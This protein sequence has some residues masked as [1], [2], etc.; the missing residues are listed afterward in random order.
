MKNR[1]FQNNEG[2]SP[3]LGF[4]LV[5]AIG[6][7]L[8]TTV[9]LSFVP[10]WNTQEELDHIKLM[11]DDFKLL[12]SNI[13]R[14]IQSGTTLSSPLIMGFKYSPKM[15]VYNPKDEAYASL[16]ISN[17]TWVEVRYNEVFYEGMTD[18]TSIKNIS[19]GMITYALLGAQNYNSFIYENGL[20]RRG[21]TNYTTNSQTV[22]AN[23]TI[24]LPGV[25]ALEYGTTSG[26]EKRTVNIYPTSQQKNSVIGK[27]VWLI[28]HTD[29]IYVDWW[30]NNL[31][32]EGATVRKK[33]RTNGIVIANVSSSLIIKM[34]EAYISTSQKTSPPHSPATRLVKVSGEDRALPVGGTTRIIVEVQDEY[35]NPV[36]NFP[37]SFSINASLTG[38][39]SNSYNNATI[40]PGSAVSGSDGRAS[41]TLTANDG[42]FY[43][44]DAS[45]T[46]YRTTLVYSASSQGGVMKLNPTPS[47]NDYVITATLKNSLGSPVTPGTNVDFETSDGILSDNSKPTAPDGTANTTLNVSDATGLKI[48]NIQVKDIAKYSA[49][50]T[51]D[52]INNIIVTAK[53]GYVFNSLD[54]PNMVIASGCVFYSTSPGNYSTK[55]CD[56]SGSSHTAALYNLL[57][58]TPYYFIING[59]RPDGSSVNSTE[60]MFVTG[61]TGDDTPPASVTG[62]NATNGSLYIIWTWTDPD[63]ADF[64][65]TDVMIDDVLVDTVEKGIQTFNATYLMPNSSHN[66]SL[67][68]VDTSNNANGTWE[69]HNSSTRSLL[70]YVFSF[71][72]ESGYGIVTGDSNAQ[73]DNDGDASALLNE[74][75]TSG[76]SMTENYTY[77]SDKNVNI[78]TIGSFGNMQS[79]ADAGAFAAFTEEAVGTPPG[80]NRTKNPGK[81]ITTGTQS[82]SYISSNLDNIDGAIDI[83]IPVISGTTAMTGYLTSTVNSGV[84]GITYWNIDPTAGGTSDISTNIRITGTNNIQYVFRPG[85]QNSKNSGT[86]GSVPSGYGWA[87]ST[88][89]DGITSAGTWSF[90][91]RTTST[92]TARSGRILVY[93]YKYNTTSGANTLLFSVIGTANHMG[94][95]P[96][97]ETITSSLQPEYVF[98]SDEYLKVEYWL[99]VI[100]ALNNAV[101]TFEANS[102]IPYVQY[103][104]NRYSLNTSYIFTETNSSS[105]WQSISI[106]DSSYGNALANVSILNFTSGKWESILTSTFTGGTSPTEHVNVLKGASGNA[107]KY[108]SGSDQIKLMYN[109]TGAKFNNTL[110]IDLINVTVAYGTSAYGLNIT[111]NTTNVPEDITSNYYLEI[112]YSRDAG[113]TGY[114]VFV[115]NGTDWDFKGYLTSIPWT[116]ANFTLS[117][118]EIINGNVDVLYLDQTPAGPTQGNLYIDYQRV[119]NITPAVP[120]GYHLDIRANHTGIPDAGSHKLQIRYNATGDNFTLQVYNGSKP[121]W[122]N[123]AALNMTSS[124][125]LIEVPLNVDYLLSD[126]DFGSYTVYNLP[127]YYV[128]VRYVDKR[129]A[130]P[131]GKLYLDYQRVNSS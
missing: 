103:S 4:I 110:G 39:P 10:V 22:L 105:T 54:I 52:S 128:D 50:I 104:K 21:G 130:A 70:T 28:L 126:G 62:I 71:S 32:K 89:I 102:A 59:S 86:P 98:N 84:G 121:G 116:V 95:S 3:V 24:F 33:D 125:T 64:D 122:D 30:E 44:I 67:R 90:R 66:I 31:E 2:V 85:V 9:Q 127:R 108:N 99:D 113:E 51:W 97:T 101:L 76:S 58:G 40:L 129:S 12:K 120:A 23:N 92:T 45:M 81:I 107:S 114:G 13:E 38:H 20:I 56:V 16:E 109:W 73:N 60:Y 18:E 61:G 46:D 100:S 57:S 118:S 80:T 26:V 8:L 94:S 15:F 91:V 36:P 17:N 106:K 37:V 117:S 87:S 88:P 11:Q 83:T 111:T 63:D 131:V 115:F 47:G 49:N 112:N 14:G 119:H 55:S 68:T 6:V 48:T 78:G 27:N 25:K 42:G 41:V 65:H 43:Y 74:T 77:V 35:N 96:T 123:K 82:G 69:K 29:P 1:K 124:M 79:A 53:S 72:N 34:G 93:V 75:S 19:T 5:L 7:S